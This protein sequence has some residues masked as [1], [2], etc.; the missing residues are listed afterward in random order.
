MV[1]FLLRPTA[2][3][4]TKIYV[5]YASGLR[6]RCMAE[7]ATATSTLNRVGRKLYTRGFFLIGRGADMPRAD[8]P[9]LGLDLQ[10]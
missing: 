9:Y 7:G 10:A 6:G 5:L 3:R 4:N 2:R 1:K 8:M